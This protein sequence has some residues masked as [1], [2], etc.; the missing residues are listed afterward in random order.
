MT[1]V[2]NDQPLLLD[3]PRAWR[4]YTGGANLET[5]HG[6]APENS[7]FPEEWIL[8][9]VEAHNAGREDI[10]E[11]LSR[12]P[13]YEY[14]TLREVIGEDPAGYLGKTHS[15]RYGKALG[16]LAKLIDSGERLT[17]QVHPDREAARRLFQS[18]YGKTECWHILGGQA[19][20][21]EQPC[22]YLGFRP[23]IAREKWKRLFDR[24]DIP[25]MLD[26]MHKIPV[27]AGDTILITGG[28][29]HAIGAGCFLIEIQEPTDYTIRI[30]R[31]TPKGLP[32]ADSMCHQ[33]LGFE[34]MF[35]CFHYDGI[36]SQEAARRYFIQQKPLEEN[37][38]GTRRL[39]I[40]P[41]HT[42]LFQ[43]EEIIVKDAVGIKNPPVFCGLYILEGS[44]QIITAGGCRPVGKGQQYFLPAG[45]GDFTLKAAGGPLRVFRF[46]GPSGK[47]AT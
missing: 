13:D 9:V 35:D 18:D 20:D 26:C 43:L 4:T 27:K 10:V 3:A 2:P 36:S 46:R 32:I 1:K 14:V 19:V 17:V 7:Q 41:E 21:G 28:T 30:E 38:G 11:G 47:Q 45:T 15:H 33:G 12:L 34:T 16:V 39:L 29:P 22:V 44:G 31:V 37:S 5:L 23:G 8:S 6:R 42:D 40:G 24:Q 25:G